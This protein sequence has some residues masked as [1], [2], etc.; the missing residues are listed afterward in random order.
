MA[1]NFYPALTYEHEL[2]EYLGTFEN[3]SPRDG[4]F[5]LYFPEQ[6]EYLILLDN[7]LFLKNNWQIDFETESIFT[8]DETSSNISYVELTDRKIPIKFVYEDLGYDWIYAIVDLI[9]ITE[10]PLTFKGWDNVNALPFPWRPTSQVIKSG[11]DYIDAILPNKPIRWN[12]DFFYDEQFSVNGSTV[13]TFSFPAAYDEPVMFIDNYSDWKSPDVS[14]FPFDDIQM[15]AVRL[16]LSEWSKV[17]NLT[18]VEVKE[19]DDIVGEL[20]FAFTDAPEIEP[21]WGWADWPSNL[22]S[23]G[24]VWVESSFRF[25]GEWA[26]STSYNFSGLMHEIGHSLGLDHPHE[27][28][29]TLDDFQDFT[30]YTIMSYNDDESTYFREVGGTEINYLVSYSP[31]VIDIAAAQYLYGAATYNDDDTTYSFDLL[32]PFIMSIWDS[33]GIDTLDVSGSKFSCFIDLEPGSYSTVPCNNWFMTD[34]LGIAYGTVIENVNAGENDDII[35]GNNEDNFLN[36]GNGNDIIRG[37]GG[38]DFFDWDDSFRFGSDKFYGG[39][40]DDVFVVDNVLDEIFEFANEGSDSVFVTVTEYTLPDNIEV[41]ETLS[42]QD[43]ILHGNDNDNTIRGNIGSDFLVGG[44][45][46]DLIFGGMGHDRIEG[47]LGNDNLFGDLGSDTFVFQSSFGN[48]IISDYNSNEDI[49]LYEDIAIDEIE[50]IS[51]DISPVGD[52]MILFL[53]GSTITFKTP[54]IKDVD[55]FESFAQLDKPSVYQ[56]DG[57]RLDYGQGNLSIYQT[58]DDRNQIFNNKLVNYYTPLI[59]TKG[60]AWTGIPIGVEETIDGYTL[61]TETVGRRGSTFIEHSV[62]T[63][64]EVARKGVKLSSLDLIGEEVRYSADFNQD[65]SIGYHVYLS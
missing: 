23:G 56:P 5:E 24:D 59:D 47:G 21:F 17:A 65:G 1:I 50:D 43:V 25:E 8:I 2:G 15:N 33:G 53:D 16:A 51:R 60:K 13:L 39:L 45:G 54:I 64:G 26:R 14:V 35:F 48:D 11:I 55:L 40:G 61:M 42:E 36:G 29:D 22:P 28:V 18:F 46:N 34:N 63:E 7:Q 20:R 3:T 10:G 52:E 4:S 49:I 6:E 37:A 12:S 38:N 9:D 44:A 32:K 57:Y 30:H 31:M 58:V 41:V 62:S 27:G 19:T